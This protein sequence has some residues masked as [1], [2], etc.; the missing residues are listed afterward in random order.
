MFHSGDKAALE[1]EEISLLESVEKKKNEDVEP[2]H[3]E[4][5]NK[6]EGKNRKEKK[7]KTESKDEHVSE[8]DNVKKIKKDLTQQKIQGQKAMCRQLFARTP[9]SNLNNDEQ[10]VDH[11]DVSAT[12]MTDAFSNAMEVLNTTALQTL[13]TPKQIRI[14]QER[15]IQSLQSKLRHSEMEM[16]MLKEENCDLKK[17]CASLH[18]LLKD[19]D[20]A[21]HQAS[22]SSNWACRSHKGYFILKSIT[23]TRDILNNFLSNFY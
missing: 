6:D 16:R 20:S 17:E 5:N 8:A 13:E 4:E 2:P 21:D 12:S 9:S 3:P 15:E 22:T 11:D 23:C 10:G 19:R 14:R 1:Q 18:T 7:R